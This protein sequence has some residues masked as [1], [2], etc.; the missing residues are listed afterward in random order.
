MGDKAPALELNTIK[1]PARSILNVHG[2]IHEGAGGGDNSFKAGAAVNIASI[3]NTYNES[4]PDYGVLYI[5]DG[6]PAFKF[7]GN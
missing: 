5:K 3:S 4:A 2:H 1:N 6:K 7:F